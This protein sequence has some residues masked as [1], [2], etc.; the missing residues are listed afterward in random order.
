MGEGRVR[1]V[2]KALL[3]FA[4]ELRKNS[5]DTENLLW[6][7]LR[8]KRLSGYKFRRQE[9]IDR[10]IV[11]FVCYES[12]VI[13]ECDGSQHLVDKEKD[14]ERDF[15]FE[16][17]GYRILRFWNNEVLK[18]TDDVLEKILATCQLPPTSNPSL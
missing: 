2:V 7:H 10:F 13:I 16:Q 14:Q 5:T 6:K 3:P 11:D 1:V 17:Q 4:R 9:P 15:W 18:N 12:R 8:S